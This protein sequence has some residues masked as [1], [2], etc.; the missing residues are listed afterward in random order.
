MAP[1][2]LGYPRP[3][4]ILKF[5]LDYFTHRGIT[6]NFD[7]RFTGPMKLKEVFGMA[8]NADGTPKR[9]TSPAYAVFNLKVSHT[10]SAGIHVSVGVKNLLNYYQTKI[11]SPLMYDSEGNLGD[12][13]YIWGPLLG[14]QIYSRVQIEL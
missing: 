13:I 4:H 9:K 7:G 3:E 14:R 5:A 10:F 1:G 6:I 12:V 8:Y 11:E 2:A